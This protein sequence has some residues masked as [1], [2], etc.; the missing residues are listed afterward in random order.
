[1]SAA[2]TEAECWAAIDRCDA[3]LAGGDMNEKLAAIGYGLDTWLAAGYITTADIRAGLLETCN[4]RSVL[5][6]V[7]LCLIGLDPEL[8]GGHVDVAMTK[9]DGRDG[10][11]DA[12]WGALVLN[13]YSVARDHLGLDRMLTPE[14]RE[15]LVRLS[16]GIE[17]RTDLACL[18][19]HRHAH[20]Q[21]SPA[22]AD[23]AEA[24]STS[25]GA[26]LA[27]QDIL[28]LLGEPIERREGWHLQRGLPHRGDE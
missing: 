8:A 25:K 16:R 6:D 23:H 17:T 18:L 14:L 24:W 27:A 10:L 12:G 9:M 13:A 22:Q 2:P 15:S 26:R 5:D 19:L 11:D 28:E 21:F 7:M 20:K 1:M 4:G 3:A